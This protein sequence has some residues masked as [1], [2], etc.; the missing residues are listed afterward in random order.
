LISRDVDPSNILARRTQSA[1]FFL[2]GVVEPGNHTQAMSSQDCDA[3]TIAKAKEIAN[4]HEHKVWDEIP[5]S[6]H[7]HAIPSTWAYKKKLGADK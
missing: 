1:A 4:M 7:H 6:S 5:R 2:S 3:W